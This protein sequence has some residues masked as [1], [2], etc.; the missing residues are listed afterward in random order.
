MLEND[1]AFRPADVKRRI[2][3]VE[4]EAINREI[5]ENM[6]TEAY[7]VV[8]ADDRRGRGDG[9]ADAGAQGLRLRHRTGLLFLKASARGGV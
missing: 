6:I 5:L 9:G 3:V 1:T 8:S 2:L 7:D 4:D